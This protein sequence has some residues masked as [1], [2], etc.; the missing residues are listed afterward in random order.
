MKR[1][2]SVIIFQDNKEHRF[3]IPMEDVSITNGQFGHKNHFQYPDHLDAKFNE[4]GFVRIMETVDP[5]D[6]EWEQ[7]KALNAK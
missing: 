4:T 6:E 7:I 1:N 2:L 5:T 3:D